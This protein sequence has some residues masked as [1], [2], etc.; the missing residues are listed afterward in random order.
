MSTSEMRKWFEH[1]ES[2]WNW[3]GVWLTFDTQRKQFGAYA[4]APGEGGVYYA[5]SPVEALCKCASAGP[6]KWGFD[7]DVAPSQ[8]RQKP[9]E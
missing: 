5:A 6:Y 8:Q 9:Q 7:E 2:A 1:V 3:R 4:E